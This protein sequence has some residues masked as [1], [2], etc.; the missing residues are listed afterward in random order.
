MEL[1][2]LLSRYR[3]KSLFLPAHNR[4]SSLPSGIKKLLRS[5]PGS[6]DLP[7]IPEWG[8]PLISEGAV[9]N[10]Q[11]LLASKFGA[12]RAWY[13][14]NG[15]TGLLQAAV[16]AAAP[17]GSAVLMPRNV[18]RS[19]IQAC[20][21]GDLIPILFDLPFA[22]D[23][24]HFSPPDLE[25]IKKIIQA[26][27]IEAIDKISAVVLVHPFYQ[28]Y[29]TNIVPFVE[30]FHEK[31]WPVIVDEA[32]GAHFA[33]EV[34]Q[35]PDSALKAN[36]DLVVHSLHKSASGL[37]QTA[38]L[39]LKGEL[40][41]PR[42][43]EKSI[44]LMQTTSPSALLL[45][46]CE[47]SLLDLKSSSGRR[48]LISNI[49]RAKEISEKLSHI[50]VPLFK[51]QDPFKLLLDTGSHGITG[52]EA[53]EW[54]ISKGLVAEL[55][56]PGCLTFCMGFSPNKGLVRTMKRN[57]DSLLSNYS[58]R[59]PLK[60]FSSPCFPLITKSSLSV[61]KAWRVTS[62]L[63]RLQDSVGKISAEMICPYPPGI[64]ILIPGELLDHDKVNWLMDQKLL[65][66]N[67]IPSLIRVI[68]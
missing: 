14:V 26:L 65:W 9:A 66:P 22:S 46:S 62:K 16:L 64:P 2:R 63:N 24:G 23:R 31:G 40:I 52:F 50:G 55:P 38:V 12:S 7:E 68:S 18:H 33:A 58:S 17:P 21:L 39:W 11:K 1:S 54:M 57:W 27:E 37:V 47:S 3:A 67:K 59:L 56:E 43:V 25:W 49:N 32:H 13:G 42:E 53:D 30:A 5:S 8:G 45:A 48:K 51:T 15:A 36:A 60:E 10:S 61:L 29:S 28:G 35:L 20:A 6:W 4:G 44:G 34:D 41:D 19:V